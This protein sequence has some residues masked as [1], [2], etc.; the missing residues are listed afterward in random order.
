MTVL[1]ELNKVRYRG[2]RQGRP[3]EPGEGE[4]CDAGRGEA[5]YE[6]ALMAPRQVANQLRVGAVIA[7]KL[8]AASGRYDDSGRNRRCGSGVGSG[9][10]PEALQVR[11]QLGRA[12]IAQIAILLEQLVDNLLEFGG[13][14]W[15]EA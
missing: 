1:G 6:H 8:R 3:Q 13:D 9:I 12:L 4:N 2:R 10:A 15:I 7:G 14:F 11:P 5:G